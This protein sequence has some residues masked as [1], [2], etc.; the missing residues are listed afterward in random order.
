MAWFSCAQETTAFAE[1]TAADVKFEWPATK[2]LSGCVRWSAVSAVQL[3]AEACPLVTLN[4][5]AAQGTQAVNQ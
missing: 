2:A 3:A 5:F 1:C 4:E